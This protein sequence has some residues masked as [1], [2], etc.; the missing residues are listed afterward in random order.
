MKMILKLNQCSNLESI[1]VCACLVCS[2]LGCFVSIA[3][4]GLSHVLIILTLIYILYKKNKINYSILREPSIVALVFLVTIIIA[5]LV[6]N[7][8]MV[9][10]F[11]NSILKIKYFIIPI[12]II[13]VLKSIKL[14]PLFYFTTVVAV[15]SSIYGAIELLTTDIN[16]NRGIT[17][18]TMSF[19]H[20]LS[21]FTVLFIGIGIYKLKT[22][23]RFHI[24]LFI[25]ITL[26][27]IYTIYATKT[28]G[29]WVSLAVGVYLIIYM[30]LNKRKLIISLTLISIITLGILWQMDKL[31]IISKYEMSWYFT[32]NFNYILR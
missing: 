23:K 5:S 31:N 26:F 17:G 7:Y 28:R 12:I 6:V 21:L 24:I 4:V 10:N 14:K 19:S 11:S 22:M 16:R 32:I 8:D 1:L 15:I 3:F 20:N 30:Q 9:S 27:F 13:F 29:A 25:V 2:V 18:S